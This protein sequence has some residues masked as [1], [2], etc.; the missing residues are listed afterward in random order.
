MTQ[1]S[2]RIVLQQRPQ[3]RLAILIDGEL[4]PFRHKT[5]MAL[6]RYCPEDVVCVIDD[7]IPGADL[8]EM[9]GVGRGVPV[10][11]SV[12]EALPYQPDYLVIGVATPDGWLPE[13]LRQQ[14]LQA[15]RSRIG[16]ISGLHSGLATD[17]NIASLACRHAVDLIDLS[18]GVDEEFHQIGTGAA[19][20]LGACRVVTVGTDSNLGKMTT[21]IQLEMWCRHVAHLRARFVATGQNGILVKGRGIRVD[22]VMGD[23]IAGA[24]QDLIRRESVD[25][26]LLLIEGQGSLLQ[27]AF[28]GVCLSLLHGACPDAM[29]LCHHAGRTKHRYSDVAIPTVRE[30]V[31]LYERMVKPLHSDAAVVAVSVNTQALEPDAADQLMTEL[32]EETGLAVADPVR[33]GDEGCRVLMD[34]VL[35]HAANTGHRIEAQPGWYR[36]RFDRIP[37]IGARPES[38]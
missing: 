18:A 9:A 37:P 27:P 5:A 16:I 10:V 20:G 25:M 30:Y 15:I 6:L 8:Q 4:E 21:G 38:A 14:V 31:D 17:P 12:Q 7:D 33:Q 24:V 28:S 13:D 3:R 35:A 34:A 36:Q 26:D 1:T 19:R 29:I 11:A 2:D 23:Y 22:R 32:H